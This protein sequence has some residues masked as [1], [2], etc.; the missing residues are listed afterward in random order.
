MSVISL[1]SGVAAQAR[2]RSPEVTAKVSS[3]SLFPQV[4][5]TGDRCRSRA[6]RS[7]R[8]GVLPRFQLLGLCTKGTAGTPDGTVAT[9]PQPGSCPLAS[10][11]GGF[12]MVPG[13]SVPERPALSGLLFPP[14]WGR[15]DGGRPP[16][17][18]GGRGQVSWLLDAGRDR[19]EA[20]P[21]E[22]APHRPAEPRGC[23]MAP[24]P[25][26]EGPGHR[27]QMAHPHPTSHGKW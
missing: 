24:L 5:G 18:D 17:W 2:T 26:L 19:T 11:R 8:V 7:G 23:P 20:R 27:P 3:Q 22:A 6:W 15:L 10:P 25:T 4:T 13:P 1:C 14:S 9:W 16:G 21:R 12:F